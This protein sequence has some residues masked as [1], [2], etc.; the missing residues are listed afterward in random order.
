VAKIKELQGHED[1]KTQRKKLS[2]FE[3]LWPNDQSDSLQFFLY[4]IR[5]HVVQVPRGISTGYA[6]ASVGI[7]EGIKLLICL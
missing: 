6:M 1:T 3:P 2:A 5:H 7:V 4:E